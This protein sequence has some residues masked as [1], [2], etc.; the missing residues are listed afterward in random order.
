MLIHSLLCETKSKEPLKDNK[1]SIRFRVRVNIPSSRFM[2]WALFRSKGSVCLISIQQSNIVWC[3]EEYIW[4]HEIVFYQK[5]ACVRTAFFRGVRN[6]ID[7]IYWTWRFS[8]WGR[9]VLSMIGRRNVSG[10]VGGFVMRLRSCRRRKP[11]LVGQSIKY[12]CQA[13]ASRIHAYATTSK[14]HS[15]EPE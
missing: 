1:C 9:Q 14:R 8:T 2:L 12:S 4:L 13:S 6:L 7:I 10:K 5:Q 15:K 3:R 11:V